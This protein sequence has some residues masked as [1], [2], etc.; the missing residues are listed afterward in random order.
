MLAV[1][2]ASVVDGSVLDLVVVYGY[3]HGRQEW[4]GEM[5]GAVDDAVPAVVLGDFNFVTDVRDR[6]RGAMNEYDVRQARK[7]GEIEGGLDLVDTYRL[8]NP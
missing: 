3:P 7:M 1:R 5:E 6:D 4:L 8:T 2:V